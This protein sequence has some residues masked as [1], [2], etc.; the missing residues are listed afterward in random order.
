MGSSVGAIAAATG[1]CLE[2]ALVPCVAAAIGA[3]IYAIGAGLAVIDRMRSDNPNMRIVEYNGNTPI[4]TSRLY[5]SYYIGGNIRN[6][7]TYGDLDHTHYLLMRT[8]TKHNGNTYDHRVYPNAHGRTA[9]V[10]NNNAHS[11][12]KN[13]RDKAEK[14]SVF[15]SA[16]GAGNPGDWNDK[17][18]DDIAKWASD[19][20]HYMV[21]NKK[22]AGCFMLSDE[23]GE[24]EK[25]YFSAVNPGQDVD[26]GDPIVGQ[27]G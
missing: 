16:V 22:D 25:M 7:T 4:K 17:S 10:T 24:V 5:D 20:A 15:L 13:K 12:T 11:D 3:G 14:P 8:V 23:N 21:D 2:Y 6:V 9:V 19:M 18:D 27:C 26:M 1:F